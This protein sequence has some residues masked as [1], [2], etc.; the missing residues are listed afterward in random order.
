LRVDRRVVGGALRPDE[1]LLRERLKPE[2]N[3]VSQQP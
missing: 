3:R 2:L 1:M